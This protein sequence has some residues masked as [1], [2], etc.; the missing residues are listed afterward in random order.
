MMGHKCLNRWEVGIYTSCLCCRFIGGRVTLPTEY[1]IQN[2]E[3]W[4]ENTIEDTDHKQ[5]NTTWK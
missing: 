5:E 4:I 3:H 2:A 1:R